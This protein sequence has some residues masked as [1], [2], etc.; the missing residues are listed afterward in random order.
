M[1]RS[2]SIFENL[3]LVISPFY[4]KIKEPRDTNNSGERYNALVKGL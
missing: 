1:Y 3:E 4:N 2:K